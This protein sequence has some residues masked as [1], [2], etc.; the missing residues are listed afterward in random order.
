MVLGFPYLIYDISSTVFAL[1]ICPGLSGT[2]RNKFTESIHRFRSGSPRVLNAPEFRTGFPDSFRLPDGSSNLRLRL[3][4]SRFQSQQVIGRHAEK[5]RKPD[6]H[7]EG[8]LS[9][10]LFIAEISH[11]ADLKMFRDLPLRQPFFRPQLLQSPAQNL[12][13]LSS[14]YFL[15]SVQY[16]HFGN[17]TVHKTTESVGNHPRNSRPRCTR[18]GIC[19]LSG[20]QI[21]NKRFVTQRIPGMRFLFYCFFTNSPFASASTTI[22]SPAENFPERIS[23]ASMVSRVCWIYRFNGRAP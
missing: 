6:Q 22:L 8:R 21:Q 18:S 23:L 14:P 4:R 7:F 3:Y 13:A 12:Y 19:L 17:K 1:A 9:L 10:S 16:Y 20:F 2:V 15:L 5:T 11:A